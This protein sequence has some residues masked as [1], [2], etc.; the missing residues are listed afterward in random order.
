MSLAQYP[1]RNN[2]GSELLPGQD[3]VGPLRRLQHR[4]NV[5]HMG[6]SFRVA[7]LRYWNISTTT[8][9]RRNTICSESGKGR[10]FR[11]LWQPR[12]R[13]TPGCR[14]EAGLPRAGLHCS[15]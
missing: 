5:C 9:L 15:H 6:T 11:S 10:R 14:S 1:S 3:P 2:P 7:S 4:R 12:H 8:P 13:V